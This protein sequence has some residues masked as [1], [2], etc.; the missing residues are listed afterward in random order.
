MWVSVYMFRC[1][2]RCERQG[3]IQVWG[4]GAYTGVWDRG[5]YRCERQKRI[6]VW[7][8]GAYTGVRD[9]A[10]TAVRDRG[11]NRCVGSGAYT[12]IF[13][14][15][16]LSEKYQKNGLFFKKKLIPYIETFII[17]RGVKYP[18]PFILYAQCL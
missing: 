10:Y 8:T 4:T 14:L 12:E 9:R 15:I 18:L 16:S 2:D 5:V 3:R 6:Q 1:K 17:L 11:V 13:V 7:G